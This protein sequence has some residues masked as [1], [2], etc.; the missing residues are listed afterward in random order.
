MTKVVLLTSSF[1]QLSE[2]FIMNKFIGLVE[3]GWDVYVVCSTSKASEWKNFPHASSLRNIRKRVHE[4]WPVQPKWLVPLFF[5][6]ALI[7]CLV[8]NFGGTFGYL[9]RGWR[10]H[11]AAILKRFYLD[12]Q[13]ITLKPDL[14]HF[15]FGAT[16]R[17]RSDLSRLLGCKEIVSFRGYDLNFSGLDQPD[18]YENVWKDA[19]AFHFL[20]EDLRNRGLR[21]GC[22]ADKPYALIPPAIDINFFAPGQKSIPQEVGVPTRPF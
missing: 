5:P 11:R 4:N 3:E 21:R 16:A 7:K 19:D 22:P 8:A 6:L 1:P 15:E 14:I 2:T 12:A 20:G 18:F 10:L 17:G 13:F 9:S